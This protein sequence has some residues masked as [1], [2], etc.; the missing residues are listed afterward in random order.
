MKH[1]AVFSSIDYLLDI[2]K[3]NRYRLGNKN[4][5]KNH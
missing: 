2:S 5:K 1:Q 3:K 4:N